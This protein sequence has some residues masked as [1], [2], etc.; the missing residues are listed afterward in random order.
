MD[1]QKIQRTM[2]GWAIMLTCFV[3]A[4]PLMAQL[5]PGEALL[6]KAQQA[7]NQKDYATAITQLEQL[8]QQFPTVKAAADGAVLL[9]RIYGLQG[10]AL[11]ADTV[12]ND[13][14]ARWPKSEY[15]WQIVDAAYQAQA[16]ANPAQA[17][18]DLEATAKSGILPP[19]ATE[20]VLAY[21]LAYLEKTQPDQFLTEAL[22][23]AA[24]ALQ[25]HT[26]ADVELPSAL[27]RRLYRP[28]MKAGRFDDAK[29]LSMATQEAIAM[30]G[31]PNDWLML[32]TTEYYTALA[33]TNTPRFLDEVQPLIETLEWAQSKE[34][35]DV[36]LLIARLAYGPLVQKDVKE[37]RALHDDVQIAL[38]QLTLDK[39]IAV[40]DGIAYFEAI[41]RY[42]PDIFLAEGMPVMERVKDIK[43][44][45]DVELPIRLTQL[46][47]YGFVI[48]AKGATAA[49]S[50]HT[51]LATVIQQYAPDRFSLEYPYYLRSLSDTGSN[52]QLL[53]EDLVVVST[54]G[55]A[56][57]AN[58]L[59]FPTD[60]LR[61]NFFSIMIGAERVEEAKEIYAKFIS[62]AT[63]LQVPAERVDLV[64]RRYFEC[65]RSALPE[66]YLQEALP[67]IDTIKTAKT[68][69]EVKFPLQFTGDVYQRLMKVGKIEDAKTLH[70]SLQTVLVK[71]DPS[72]ALADADT[73]TYMESFSTG[74]LDGMLW[75]FKR[76][77]AAGDMDTAKKWLTILN[78]VAPEDKRAIEARKLYKQAQ[79]KKAA[80]APAPKEGEQP[81]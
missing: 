56:R 78:T 28:L 57:T 17:W 40:R 52:E 33:E 79:E 77:L 16:S 44:A 32:D 65:L 24:R 20:R 2:L 51:Q 72:N 63:R 25:A 11:K 6:Q 59:Y 80:P 43:T 69:D 67:V 5:L 21:R 4:L 45:P 46:G 30:L 68:V 70:E 34:D 76:A 9:Y 60:C 47:F 41:A 74:A 1:M 22:P 18:A 35:T 39:M 27:A 12:R 23:I 48:Q 53:K 64:R 38:A 37:A 81:K 73:K 31:N 26:V 49:E 58:D 42:K 61:G 66:Q 71:L 3:G 7:Y 10:Q 13:V 36:P 19:A 54:M 14:I 29:A 8:R 75:L 55:N 15:V 62:I 50:L